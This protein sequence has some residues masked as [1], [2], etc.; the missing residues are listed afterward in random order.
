MPR[1]RIQGLYLQEF[2]G[3][4]QP[5][6]WCSTIGV[7][8]QVGFLL[9]PVP[10][11]GAQHV[12]FPSCKDFLGCLASWIWASSFLAKRASSCGSAPFLVL[13]QKVQILSRIFYF[14][15]LTQ[16]PWLNK[17]L[18]IFF[19]FYCKTAKY[20]YNSQ[21]SIFQYLIMF[22]KLRRFVLYTNN[23]IIYMISVHFK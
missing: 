14:H 10:Y 15:G 13:I 8:S 18:D 7:T 12:T 20:H 6:F 21:N 17:I 16:V 22:P 23:T 19:Y 1:M 9:S 5:N 11:V 4:A 2:L 3:S